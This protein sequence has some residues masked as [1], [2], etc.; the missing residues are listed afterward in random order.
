MGSNY[1]ISI[2]VKSANNKSLNRLL[3]SIEDSITKQPTSFSNVELILYGEKEAVGIS[4]LLSYR[5]IQTNIKDEYA[6]LVFVAEKAKG[7]ILVFT[8]ANILFTENFLLSIEEKVNDNTV[9][10]PKIISAENNNIIDFGSYVINNRLLFP[11]RGQLYDY[12]HI[13]SSRDAH[14]SSKLM[15]A[16]SKPLFLSFKHKA[17]NYNEM[18]DL[19]RKNNIRIVADGELIVYYNGNIPIVER[20]KNV[21][22]EDTKA[23]ELLSTGLAHL[24]SSLLAKDYLLIDLCDSDLTDITVKCLCEN[25][26]NIV[27][28]YKYNAGKAHNDI[29]LIS[30]LPLDFINYHT[31]IIYFVNSFRDLTN[32]SV[33]FSARNISCDLIV[34]ESLNILHMFQL[35][36]NMI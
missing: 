9:I 19:C 21:F 2:I 20:V 15:I 4:T 16:I 5:F 11:N 35:A 26:L 24:N 12:E 29:N 33:W 34:D 36:N 6:Q 14:S 22:A 25:G 10:I 30:T 23:Y 13:P 18:Y 27:S 3:W 31:A 17:K 1:M 28:V 8:S 32:N 7:N